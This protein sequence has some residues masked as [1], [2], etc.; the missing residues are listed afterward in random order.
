M[1]ILELEGDLASRTRCVK[2][3]GHGKVL[4]LIP[5]RGTT[6]QAQVD[7]L[8]HVAEYHQQHF[9]SHELEVTFYIKRVDLEP[10][11]LPIE[12]EMAERRAKFVSENTR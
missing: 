4:E 12:T 8:I 5:T 9:P 2:G 10:I 6:T 3:C 11:I 1:K 7:K